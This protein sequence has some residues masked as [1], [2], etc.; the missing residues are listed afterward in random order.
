MPDATEG[1]RR[2]PV[3]GEP[4]GIVWNDARN[5]TRDIHAGTPDKTAP[6]APEGPAG[7]FA[8]STPGP[9]TTPIILRSKPDPMMKPSRRTSA[10]TGGPGKR[11][12]SRGKTKKRGYIGIYYAR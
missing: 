6:S 2:S 1:R 10:G 7:T 12:R 8:P 11:I 5:G 9:V 4:D 3:A